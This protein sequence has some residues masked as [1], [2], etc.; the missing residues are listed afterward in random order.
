MFVI[1]Y[2]MAPETAGILLT[3]FGGRCMLGG[4]VLLSVVGLLVIRK[5][6]NVR[7]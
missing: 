5:I 7:I 3:T 1:M 6:T 2:L 4:A